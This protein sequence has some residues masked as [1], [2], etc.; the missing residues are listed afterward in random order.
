MKKTKTVKIISGKEAK[1][2]Q[3]QF[4]KDFGSQQER[5][6]GWQAGQEA[7]KK[8]IDQ[9]WLEY[10][11]MANQYSGA[12]RDA[13]LAQKQGIFD[14]AKAKLQNENDAKY[15]IDSNKNNLGRV[16]KRRS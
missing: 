8:I 16:I 11:Q 1:I 13:L 5:Y 12:T 7:N 2:L 9:Q 10:D 14:R 6:K 4:D 15:G 3:E